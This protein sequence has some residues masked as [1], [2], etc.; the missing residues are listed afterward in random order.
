MRFPKANKNVLSPAVVVHFPKAGTNVLSRPRRAVA[1]GALHQDSVYFFDM[2][3]LESLLISQGATKTLAEAVLASRGSGDSNVM[4][5]PMGMT[6]EEI[7]DNLCGA[8]AGIADRVSA[9]LAEIKKAAETHRTDGSGNLKFVGDDDMSTAFK[10]TG[11]YESE[12]VF[13]EGLEKY[14]S[15]PDP[16]VLSAIVN[17]YQNAAN[18]DIPY[19][20]SNYILT[21]KPWKELEAVL[22][23][24]AGKIYPGMGTGKGKH[25]LPPFRVYLSAAGCLDV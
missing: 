15:L 13:H 5:A 3:Q 17:E 25:E 8:V 16:K 22:F 9:E 2:N 10:G 18:S 23:P 19:V 11:K 21:C 24:K 20:T 6:R 12:L 14:I 1:S 4:Q 7:H